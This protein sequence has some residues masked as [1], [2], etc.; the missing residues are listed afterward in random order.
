MATVL[1]TT[2]D[3]E[4]HKYV[5]TKN[6]EKYHQSLFCWHLVAA[7]IYKWLW[8]KKK[9]WTWN[10]VTHSIFIPDE[11]WNPF[12][13]Q[14]KLCCCCK[15]H[16]GNVH[17][18]NEEINYNRFMFYVSSNDSYP[19]PSF[20]LPALLFRTWLSAILAT[21]FSSL[22]PTAPVKVRGVLCLWADEVGVYLSVWPG[23]KHISADG[24][25]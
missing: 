10:A 5:A 19:H 8:G 23:V 14:C 9:I 15:W 13:T 25:H 20:C 4:C 1:Y 6:C 16:P 24:W 7:D 22:H 3:E 2:V 11:H 21:L 12:S 17:F 18:A